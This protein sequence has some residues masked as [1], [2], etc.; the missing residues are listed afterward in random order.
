MSIVDRHLTAA[1]IW[2]DPKLYGRLIGDIAEMEMQEKLA[3][4]RMNRQQRAYKQ[5]G[6]VIEKAI[7]KRG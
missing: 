1:M 4:I 5:A 7:G 6:K 3:E 2:H